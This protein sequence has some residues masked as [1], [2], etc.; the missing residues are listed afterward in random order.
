MKCED[1]EK[2]MYKMSLE[3]EVTKGFLVSL[4]LLCLYGYLREK[5]TYIIY[6][7]INHAFPIAGFQCHAFQNKE[8][9]PFN[10]SS[11]ESGNRKKVDMQRPSPRFR[12]QPFFLWKIC[13]ETFSPNL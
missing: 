2:K 6:N 12:S 9:K 1:K 4:L 11:P 5:K 3:T 13:G 10:R 8:S 7:L